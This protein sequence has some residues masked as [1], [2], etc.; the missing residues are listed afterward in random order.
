MGHCA[1]EAHRTEILAAKDR[2]V[3]NCRATALGEQAVAKPTRKLYDR[4]LERWHLWLSMMGI[5]LLIPL[6]ALQVETCLS[7]YLE[8]L[9]Q[10]GQGRGA[11]GTILSA[12]QDQNPSLKRQLL[13]GW[14]TFST[15]RYLELGF[16]GKPGQWS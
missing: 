7:E 9:W 10:L 2:D 11:A 1:C 16:C 14:R 3:A 6:E 15:W 4:A 13:Q 5:A 12:V 8:Y